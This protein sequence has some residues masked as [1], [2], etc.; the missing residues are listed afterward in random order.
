[1]LPVALSACT[2]ARRD[3]DVQE[4]CAECE[5]DPVDRPFKVVR[6]DPTLADNSK[7]PQNLQLQVGRNILNYLKTR[8]RD[9]SFNVPWIPG[10]QA[11][12]ADL[13]LAVQQLLDI[14]VANGFALRAKVGSLVVGKAGGGS[15]KIVVE[16]PANLWGVQTLQFRRAPIADTFDGLAVL[17]FLDAAGFEGYFEIEADS[18]SLEQSWTI[19]PK[20]AARA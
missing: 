3:P 10:P 11:T 18:A 4:Y 14:F 12:L 20:Q 1:L 6:R 2:L 15:W 16:G 17:A 8:F 19:V 13:A 9:E 5:G 7:L